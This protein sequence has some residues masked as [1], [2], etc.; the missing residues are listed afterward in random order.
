VHITLD[1][2]ALPLAEGVAEV[3]RQLDAD[4]ASFAASAGED[5][6]LCVCLPARARA[7]VEAVW[8]ATP[9]APLTWIGR[10]EEGPAG[11]AFP[12]SAGELSGYEHSP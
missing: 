8:P 12:G 5:Y 11:L 3:A 2:A 1:L 6:E 9:R 4:P 10:V 7:A